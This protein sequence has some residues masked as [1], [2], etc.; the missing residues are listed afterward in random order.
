VTIYF[1]VFGDDSAD[2][3]D[4]ALQV[5]YYATQAAAQAEVNRRKAVERANWELAAWQVDT[6]NAERQAL[7]QQAIRRVTVL[8]ENGFEE[9]DPPEPN[10]EA[11]PTWRAWQAEK[12]GWTVEAVEEAK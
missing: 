4:D 7:Y 11:A 5:G 1:V 8:R 12:Y 9:Y 3:W 6:V 10:Y 2:A